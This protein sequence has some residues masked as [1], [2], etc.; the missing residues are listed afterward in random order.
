[1]GL[2]IGQHMNFEAQ[3]HTPPPPPRKYLGHLK[4]IRDRYYGREGVTRVGF[5]DLGLKTVRFVVKLDLTS[6]PSKITHFLNFSIAH[7]GNKWY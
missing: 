4:C 6:V 2:K 5:D 3:S 1:M 7:K